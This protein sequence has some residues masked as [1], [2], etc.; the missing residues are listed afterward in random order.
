MNRVALKRWRP[1]LLEH[2]F[3]KLVNGFAEPVTCIVCTACDAV[4]RGHGRR[5]RARFL[6]VHRCCGLLIPPGGA[7]PI[8]PGDVAPHPDAAPWTAPTGP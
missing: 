2:V 6:K 7:R 8:H 4:G 1:W 3:F 5:S